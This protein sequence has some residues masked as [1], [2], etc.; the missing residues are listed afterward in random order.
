MYNSIWGV[1]LRSSKGK[2]C[3]A[4]PQLNDHASKSKKAKLTSPLSSVSNSSKP[5]HNNRDRARYDT[6]KRAFWS[7][8]K[9]VDDSDNG[10]EDKEERNSDEDSQGTKVS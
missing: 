5:S 1:S 7:G 3:S 4:P 9:K 2:K 10:D 6:Q 8:H